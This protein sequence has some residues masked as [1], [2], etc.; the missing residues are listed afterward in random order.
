MIYL[1]NI[2]A[3]INIKFSLSILGILL[4]FSHGI[5]AQDRS[6]LES[7]RQ[8]LIREI[9]QTEQDLQQTKKTKAV[10]L[11]QYLALQSQI[12][13][14]KALVRTLKE[15]IGIANVAIEEAHQQLELLNNELARLKEEYAHTIQQAYRLRLNNSFLLFLFSA[16]SFDDA[17]RRWQYLRQ[18]DSNRKRQAQ[19]IVTTQEQLTAESAQLEKQKIEKEQ[20]LVSQEEQTRILAQDLNEKNRILKELNTSEGRLVAELDKQQKA[21][22]QLNSAIESI[23]RKEMASR[24]KASRPTTSGNNSSDNTDVIAATPES[25]TPLSNN[26]S[27]N[28][29]QLPW[30][31]KKGYITRKFGKQP[32]PQ[33][34]SIQITNN[35]ID[36]RS[37]AGAKVYPVFE[38]TIAGTQFIPGY[39]NT[40]IVKHGNYYTAYSNLEQINV[41]RGDAVG[42]GE[43]I[44]KLGSKK[45]EVHFEV[46]QGKKRLNPVYWVKEQ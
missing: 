31:V 46:W 29:G 22:D 33:V 15:E 23:I 42:P 26:F 6:D 25:D 3:Q 7:Q 8:R 34:R 1:V 39:L 44:G 18:Y 45:P 30:P 16:D 38:G 14:R 36:I 35:G 12:Q 41:K 5:Y 32:H 27:N 40:V 28:K 37:E 9:K 24:A 19:D 20:L 13:K 11:D 4:L 43:A 17:Y 2:P 10:T 21:H